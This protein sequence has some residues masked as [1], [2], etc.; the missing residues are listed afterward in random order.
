MPMMNNAYA[1]IVGIAN[2][3][4][5]NQLPKTVLK[6]AQDVYD[7][8]IDPRYCGYARDNVQLL[9]DEQATREG[10][11][12][13]LADLKKSSADSTVCIYISSHG[14]QVASGAEK[15]EYL[16]PVDAD[17]TS[18][19]TLAQT[20]ISNAQFTESLRA[21]PAQKLLVIF[22]CCHSGGVGQP[23][24][25]AAPSLIS[26]FSDNYYEALKQGRGRV[27]LASSRSNEYSYILPGADNSLFTQ[28]LLA[29]LRG[30]IPSD[31]GSIRIFD[32]FEYL[33]PRVTSDRSD[34]HPIFKAEIEENFPIALYVGGQKGAIP[35]VEDR[36]RYDAYISYVDAG[37]DRNWVR[38][39]LLPRLKD[40]GLKIAVS[41]DVEDPGVARVVN[42]ER[43][44]TQAKRTI[45]VLSEAY[46]RDNM[47]EFI[48]TLVQY[49]GI[50]EGTYRL[51]P[52][53]AADF[54][55]SLLP[56]RLSMLSTLDLSDPYYAEEDFKRLIGALQSPLP[57]MR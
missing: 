51:L 22:D 13:A 1:L 23:K 8:L 33:Q 49:M 11:L 41:R 53:K 21:I 26:G 30:G 36:F 34:Q 6:D 7:L 16:L 43:G 25:I 12:G 27:I 28:H 50:N 14:G 32:V 45:I 24:D 31:D 3:Q 48:N 29:G 42:I 44:V 37:F 57:K 15:G 20:A 54:D 9:L 18:G 35:Q 39:N 55:D 47:A 52:I 5:V 4:K 19:A 56:T 2:Y 10:I 38:E 40:A 46:L 17:P